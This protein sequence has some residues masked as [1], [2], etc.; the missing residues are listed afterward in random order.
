M[1]A[2]ALALAILRLQHLPAVP[3]AAEVRARLLAPI[4]LE[5]AA[6]RGLDPILIA[7]VIQH[8]S[9]FVR[10]A[11][12]SAGE[13]GLMQIKRGTFA[14]RGYEHLSD[15]ALMFPRYNVMLGARHLARVRD[16]C[17]GKRGI[18]D[19]LSWLSV[20]KG[21]RCRPSAYSRAIVA[22]ADAAR[23]EAI[24]AAAIA[25][26]EKRPAKRKGTQ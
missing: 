18:T 17:A 7:S 13:L 8:E 16:V 23:R 14:T 19:P 24:Q 4:I 1:T 22:A 11:R 10:T 3:G 2:A 15:E 21:L 12:G 26:T 20:Y 9:R 5:A 6:H 25:E